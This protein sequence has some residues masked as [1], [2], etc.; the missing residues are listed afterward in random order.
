MQQ[1]YE[2]GSVVDIV[3]PT[4]NSVR[5]S[6]PNHRQFQQLLLETEAE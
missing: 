5:K 3:V 1:S 6:A 2:R 4:V